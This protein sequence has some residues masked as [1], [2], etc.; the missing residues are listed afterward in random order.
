MRESFSAYLSKA[1]TML[2]LCVSVEDWLT[3]HRSVALVGLADDPEI[4]RMRGDLWSGELR[5][6]VVMY[7][8]GADTLIPQLA[9]KPMQNGQPTGYVCQAFACS[10]PV[11]TASGLRKIRSEPLPT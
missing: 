2:G 7:R 1:P 5:P 9:D 8:S 10:A 3:D 6:M 11:H 4:A